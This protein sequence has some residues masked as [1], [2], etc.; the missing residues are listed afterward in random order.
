MASRTLLAA[1][2]I[3]SLGAQVG[4]QTPA[5]APAAPQAKTDRSPRPGVG[6]LL[7]APQRIIFEGGNRTEELTLVNVG[8][9]TATYRVSFIQMDMKEDGSLTE[10]TDKR[11]DGKYVDDIVRYSPRQVTLEPGASQ[12]VRISLRK[13]EG[14]P[15][16]EY[17]SHLVFRAV[18]EPE[19]LAAQGNA[20]QEEAAQ[21]QLS[22]RL[23]P[24]YGVAVPIIVRHGATAGSVTWES[25]R[26]LPGPPPVLEAILAR[27]GNQSVYG[28]L[29]V[30]FTPAGT[31]TPVLVYQLNM[32]AVY[33]GLPRRRFSL[34]LNLPGGP[35]A[36]GTLQIRFQYPDS[37]KAQAETSLEIR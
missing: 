29:R 33:D 23:I 34:P 8:P 20:Q 3:L 11:P 1:S 17:R 7:V 10:Y 36:K 26:V 4:A 18:P 24:I 31:S 22:V 28:D 32:G 6:D 5:Q 12:T 16:G 13:P 27:T 25:A 14:L 35:G 9:R 37:S 2:V 21:T 30:L 15:A 19:T